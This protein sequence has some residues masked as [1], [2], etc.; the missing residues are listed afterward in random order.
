[1]IR[2][3]RELAQL[4]TI[5]TWALF[6]AGIVLTALHIA[7][8]LLLWLGTLPPAKWLQ[9]G[10]TI[11]LI[12]ILLALDLMAVIFALTKGK[13]SV[14]GPG[15]MGFDLSSGGTDAPPTPAVTVTTEVNKS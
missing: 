9:P 12:A 8:V 2:T 15:N 11:S 14:K 5:S 13:A 6:G 7:V 4:A 3:L 10:D 1:M